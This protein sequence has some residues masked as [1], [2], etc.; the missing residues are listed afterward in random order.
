MNAT[1]GK[2]VICVFIHPSAQSERLRLSWKKRREKSSEGPL[3]R[4]PF[5]SRKRCACTQ[6][7]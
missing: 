3:G 5:C 6:T 1:K 7:V 2:C 4:A